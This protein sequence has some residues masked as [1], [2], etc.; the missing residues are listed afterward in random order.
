MSISMC[1]R[2]RVGNEGICETLEMER[3][4]RWTS[5]VQ[6]GGSNREDHVRRELEAYGGSILF[7]F[8]EMGSG[9]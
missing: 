9:T 1:Y 6:F 2:V 5:T 7:C 8:D 3:L 4:M